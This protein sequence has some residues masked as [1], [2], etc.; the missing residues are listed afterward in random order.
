MVNVTIAANMIGL[1]VYTLPRQELHVCSRQTFAEGMKTDVKPAGVGGIAS[2][3][4]KSTDD[5]GYRHW[6]GSRSL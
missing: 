6:M 4:D 5:V 3:M 2:M 1:A